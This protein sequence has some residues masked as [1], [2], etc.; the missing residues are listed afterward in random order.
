MNAEYIQRGESLDYKNETAK[1]INA[2]EVVVFGTRI[3]IAGTTIPVGSTGS[4]HM[5]GVFKIP[6]KDG[7]AIEKGAIVYYSEDGLTAIAAE[8]QSVPVAGFAVDTSVAASKTVTVK[9]IG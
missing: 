5:V 6:K 8:E 2:G 9:L 3:G 4:I 1:Q 7:E